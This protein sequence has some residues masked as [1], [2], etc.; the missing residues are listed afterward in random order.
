[1]MR[2]QVAPVGFSA[3]PTNENNED[4]GKSWWLQTDTG[5]VDL[6][7][8]NVALPDFDGRGL[9]VAMQQISGH[10]W[11]EWVILPGEIFGV[12]RDRRN[13]TTDMIQW[14][15]RPPPLPVSAWWV[16][17]NQGWCLQKIGPLP[18]PFDNLT[19]DEDFEFDRWQ[20]R[21]VIRAGSHF[22]SQTNS[23]KGARRA[24]C[25]GPSSAPA[26]DMTYCHNCNV[27]G[28]KTEI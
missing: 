12:Q 25:W 5:W 9:R 2:L 21:I 7:S 28:L 14:G 8:L 13:G 27:P 10:S 15:R 23:R 3:A 18:A 19:I 11:V 20:Y 17:S 16:E 1:M 26:D 24:M 6:N 4:S 22:G